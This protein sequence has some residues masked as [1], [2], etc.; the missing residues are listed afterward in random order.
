M[1]I[2][3]NELHYYI[4]LLR[5]NDSQYRLTGKT[6]SCINALHN[7]IRTMRCSR[8]D[9][10]CGEDFSK[11]DWGN[12]PLKGI[13]F[14]L[15]GK[16]PS[17]FYECKMS[18]E[19]YLSG[20]C[21]I[22][23]DAAWSTDGKFILTS[24]HDGTICVW[25]AESY[26]MKKRLLPPP[27]FDQRRDKIKLVYISDNNRYCMGITKNHM[28]FVWNIKTG[29]VEQR[30]EE[31]DRIYCKISDEKI[32]DLTTAETA[33]EWQSIRLLENELWEKIPYYYYQH[34]D[35]PEA[36]EY[37]RIKSLREKI[38]SKLHSREELYAISKDHRYCLSINRHECVAT[39]WDAEEI[40][41]IRYL[42]FS[43]N[44]ETEM[45]IG[46]LDYKEIRSPLTLFLKRYE[47]IT[48]IVWNEKICTT[49]LQ[50]VKSACRAGEGVIAVSPDGK[51]CATNAF[52]EF[53]I[54]IR[55]VISG[56]M[57]RQ[58]TDQSGEITAVAIS[59]NKLVGISA[60]MDGSVILWD[61][62]DYKKI[63]ELFGDG[64]PITN[65]SLSFDGLLCTAGTEGGNAYLWEVNSGRQ[66]KCFKMK[67][68]T[69][70]SIAPDSSVCIVASERDFVVWKPNANDV[71]FRKSWTERHIRCVSFS[72]D[73]TMVAISSRA[74]ERWCAV[75]DICNKTFFNQERLF[76]ASGLGLSISADN[77]MI[78]PHYNNENKLSTLNII[79][80]ESQH[81][82]D[83]SAWPIVYSTFLSHSND[84][85]FALNFNK[86]LIINFGDHN[87]T[88]IPIYADGY[89]VTVSLDGDIIIKGTSSG[90][91]Q[92]FDTKTGNHL[93]E[94]YHIS[95][96]W[97]DNCDFTDILSDEILKRII[98]QN[99]GIGNL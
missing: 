48:G 7:V 69:F 9:K 40:K 64:S 63:R 54:S 94:V 45:I 61:M 50:C 62:G 83:C 42:I 12:I 49:D 89:G 86:G 59:G 65:V 31:E 52:G 87:V 93:D 92:L 53:F 6:D 95:G 97:I 2:Q 17:K 24:S 82:C 47:C 8:H 38:C 60:T 41:E 71:L 29:V 26:I 79:G 76:N 51:R 18:V 74:Y 70:C 80:N 39:V 30:I 96:C 43:S 5:K 19:N 84:V 34:K 81:F 23:S 32:C 35:S 77:T 55:E 22:I 15:N 3:K 16:C 46:I 28:L 4:D 56:R 88:E 90:S 98:Y 25:S 68:R 33:I 57:I 85:V 73:S 27:P 66:I 11:L 36:V 75:F 67:Y 99:G 20:H 72:Q 21:D 44:E 91:L 14:S 13:K 58:L 10:V 78:F 1:I 37:A